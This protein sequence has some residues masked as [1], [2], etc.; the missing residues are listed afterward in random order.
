MGLR[1]RWG[2]AH[3]SRKFPLITHRFVSLWI[4]FSVTF[5]LAQKLNKKTFGFRASPLILSFVNG[6]SFSATPSVLHST[7][8]S[9]AFVCVWERLGCADGPHTAQNYRQHNT[10][11]CLWFWLY[12]LLSSAE[13][14]PVTVAWRHSSDGLVWEK[15]H[16]W[17][18]ELL[19]LNLTSFPELESKALSP[20]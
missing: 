2:S 20:Q 8:V 13:L 17:W 18:T 6:V 5:Y 15:G 12:L 3:F 1:L 4:S 10:S 16:Q 9:T 11:S 7:L 14:C 19:D